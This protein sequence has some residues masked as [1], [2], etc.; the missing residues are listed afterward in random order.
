MNLHHTSSRNKLFVPN[1]SSNL[2]MIS[3]NGPPLEKWN[4]KKY[5]VLSWI[6]SGRHAALNK[7]SGAP[8]QIVEIKYGAKLFL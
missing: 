5:E 1:V 4:A 8:K 7:A 3:I 6:K 2:M